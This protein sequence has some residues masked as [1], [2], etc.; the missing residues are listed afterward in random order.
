MQP[1][2]QVP[3]RSGTLNLQISPQ[4]HPTVTATVQVSGYGQVHSDIT[5]GGHLYDIDRNSR[6]S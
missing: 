3:A 1:A 2:G 5:A 6:W 4:S